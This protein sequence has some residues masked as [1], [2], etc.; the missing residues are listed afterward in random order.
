VL[1]M[2]IERFRDN[3]MIPVYRHLRDQGRVLPE[4]LEY[5]DSWIEPSFARC[6]QLMRCADPRL[7]QEWTLQWRG[8][9][10]TME[11][12]PVVP[13]KA[14]REVVAPYLGDPV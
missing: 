6:F 5:V 12:V 3:D 10:V 2:V 14:T 9:G 8:L 7:L 13:S 11:F 4:G 1:F